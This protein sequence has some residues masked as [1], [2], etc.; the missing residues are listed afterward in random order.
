M[1]L[2]SLLHDAADILGN[3]WLVKDGR[4]VPSA[5]R[6]SLEGN[7]ASEIEA[8]VLYADMNGSTKMVRG[9]KNWFAAEMYKVYLHTVSE[10][11]RA[12]DGAITAFDGDRVMAVFM[13]GSKN[14]SAV[15]AAMQIVY[16]VKKMN[17]LIATEYKSVTYRIQHSIGIDTGKLFAIRAGVRG[18]NDIVWVG[19]AA[20]LAAKLTTIDDADYPIW[21]TKSVYE[22]MNNTVRFSDNKNM[23]IE[24]SELKFGR[25]VY[26]TNWWWSIG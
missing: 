10:V 11:L 5:D 15:K 21:I 20:N 9:Y 6:L 16:A 2:K 17:E 3:K 22:A 4:T 14:T 8:T 23:W 13:G 1:T 24:E 18:A 7:E 19:E 12:N 26:K 25:S